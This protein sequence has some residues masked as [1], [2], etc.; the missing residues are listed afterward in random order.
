MLPSLADTEA[1]TGPAPRVESFDLFAHANTLCVCMCAQVYTIL[2]CC[3]SLNP[4]KKIIKILFL[5][6]CTAK[7]Y[8]CFV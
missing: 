2:H 7:L 4:P 6:H 3:V 5:S 1:Y 8:A